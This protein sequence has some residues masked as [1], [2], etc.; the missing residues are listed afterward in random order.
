M[1]K[2]NREVYMYTVYFFL[3]VGVGLVWNSTAGITSGLGALALILI[4]LSQ[5]ENLQRVL[6]QA[7][8][9]GGVL[10]CALIL[11]DSSVRDLSTGAYDEYVGKD[12]SLEGVV[13]RES[14]QRDSYARIV[15][16]LEAD[17]A[18]LVRAPR[19][20]EYNY[21]DSV[22]LAGILKRPESFVGDTGRIFEY[23]TYLQSQGIGYTISYPEITKLGEKM[24]NPTKQALFDLKQVFI[25]RLSTL[26]PEPHVSLL[27]GLL[28]GSK[29]AMGQELIDDF[30]TTGVI[31]IVVLSGFNITIVVY[32]VMSILSRLGRRTAGM[33][34]ALFILA[35][36]IMTGAGATVVR[37]SIMAL[38]VI[39][40][41]LTGNQAATLRMLCVAGVIMVAWNPLILVYDPSFQLSF[42]ATLGLILLSPYVE[43]IISRV[44]NSS[45][46]PFRELLAATIATQIMVTPLLLWM[47]G[48][49]PTYSLFANFLI[50]A[51]VPWVMLSGFL[52][53]TISLISSH[54]A[55]AFTTVTYIILS[56][57][58]G[59]VDIFAHLPYAE[60]TLPPFSVWWVVI[61]YSLY[62]GVGFFFTRDHS[63]RSPTSITSKP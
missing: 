15:V 47:M 2:N 48:T 9:L 40:A 28:V 62:T 7:L 51:T 27:A 19:Y 13:C 17:A 55:F 53:G 60:F 57:E 21:G 46:A 11:I 50:L 37:A 59:V 18:V 63:N 25:A 58:L 52:A 44:P 56:Y 35:F 29:Q 49:F 36:A 4:L 34:S 14:E 20:S 31:H 39:L 41:R 45:W 10:V 1:E 16:C 22:H 26:L 23:D 38:L 24:G 33:V 6:Y 43:K 42:V 54:V 8:M 5:R 30:R 32:F 61:I 3:I 12:I